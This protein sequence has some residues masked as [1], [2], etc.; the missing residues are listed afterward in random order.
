MKVI[1]EAR[2][3]IDAGR[4]NAEFVATVVD[5]WQ[6]GPARLHQSRTSEMA[7]AP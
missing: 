1:R 5:A 7:G 6:G 4:R 2:A 3:S